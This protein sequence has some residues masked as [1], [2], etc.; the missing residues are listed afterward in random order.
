MTIPTIRLCIANLVTARTALRAADRR[1]PF[2]KWYKGDHGRA[3][4]AVAK[5]LKELI[6]ALTKVA[7]SPAHTALLAEV[8][9]VR[10]RHA[11][12]DGDF[13]LDMAVKNWT[14]VYTTWHFPGDAI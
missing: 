13:G 11:A 9:D 10:D 7:P 8:K 6:A 4:A 12:K 14:D 5:A 3:R 1:T 2:S